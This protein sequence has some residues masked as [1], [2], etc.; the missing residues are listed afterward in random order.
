[1]DFSE[2]KYQINDLNNEFISQCMKVKPESIGLDDRIGS[3]FV[4]TDFS[5]IAVHK[6][7]NKSIR[8]YG[9]FEYIGDKYIVEVG[10]YVYYSNEDS[11][12]ERHLSYLIDVNNQ[13]NLEF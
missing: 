13:D 8:Y 12:V 9:G 4:P 5:C 11:R 6:S 2:F 7:K 3:V 1:M 10:D